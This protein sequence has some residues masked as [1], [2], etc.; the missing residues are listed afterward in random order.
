M[1]EQS[2]MLEL[3]DLTAIRKIAKSEDEIKHLLPIAF[4]NTCH[5][6]T[7]KKPMEFMPVVYCTVI[8]PFATYQCTKC[9]TRLLIFKEPTDMFIWSD[10]YAG[11]TD[12]SAF[13]EQE[14]A[15]R[16]RKQEVKALRQEQE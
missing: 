13:V 6:R 1:N 3:F 2:S 11:S 9:K 14:I 15:A 10:G 7:C 16:A 8:K 12:F 5:N 4:D